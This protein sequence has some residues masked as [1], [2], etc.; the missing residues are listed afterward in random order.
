MNPIVRDCLNVC[1]P[2]VNVYLTLY[3]D[4]P[5]SCSTAIRWATR[6][7]NVIHIARLGS[8]AT[9]HS[10]VLSPRCRVS[11]RY[12]YPRSQIRTTIPHHT[13]VFVVL[14]RRKS[15]RCRTIRGT[16]Q[17]SPTDQMCSRAGLGTPEQMMLMKTTDRNMRSNGKSDILSRDIVYTWGY[18]HGFAIARFDPGFMQEGNVFG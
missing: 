1:R 16:C 14:R 2:E 15:A 18:S 8:H 12:F 10:K 4:E 9:S 5:W 6:P 11:S 7:V 17:R 3:W 13:W